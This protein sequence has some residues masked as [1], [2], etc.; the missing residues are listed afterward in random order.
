MKKI[1]EGVGKEAPIE[2]LPNGA[3]QSAP[4][5]RLDLIPM[6]ALM[7]VGSVLQEGAE[8]YGIDNWRGIPA[9]AH[10]N[11][12]LIHLAAFLLGDT[13]DDHIGH[14]C[15]RMQMALEKHLMDEEGKK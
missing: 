15:C 1:I 2:T 9:S 10:I 12:V 11:K 13:Q 4:P 8:K 5:A 3:K 6:R 14:A 7:R